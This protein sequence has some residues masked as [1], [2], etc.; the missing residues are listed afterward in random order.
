MPSKATIVEN[1]FDEWGPSLYRHAYRLTH[2]LDAADDLVQEAFLALHRALLRGE[3]VR[4]PRAWTMAAVRHLACN[5]RRG[6]RRHPTSLAPGDELDRLPA[7]AAEQPEE[8]NGIEEFLSV[9]TPREEEV[10]LLRLESRKYGEIA[11]RLGIQ[12]RTVSTLLCRAL[13]KM[14][15]MAA[16]QSGPRKA[17]EDQHHARPP[18]Q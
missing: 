5:L 3:D 17:K 12:P 7:A 14:Q 10:V 13:R 6:H 16:G 4:N 15:A 1:L 8:A 2:S 18:L 11:A 9:L